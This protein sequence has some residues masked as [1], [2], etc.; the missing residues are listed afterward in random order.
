M[1]YTVRVDAV[2]HATHTMNADNIAPT[3][4]SVPTQAVT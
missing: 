2:A 3:S 4:V 1:A